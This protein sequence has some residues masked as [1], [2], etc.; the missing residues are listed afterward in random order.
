[1]RVAWICA[2]FGISLALPVVAADEPERPTFVEY[3]RKSAVP[4]ANIDGFL[5]GPSWARFDPELGY[6]LGNDLPAD[7]IDHSATDRR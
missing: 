5:R 3:L 2:L 4:R 6:V 7:G 1:M